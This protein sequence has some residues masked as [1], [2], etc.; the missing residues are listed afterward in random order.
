MLEAACQDPNQEGSWLLTQ[1]DQWW[2]HGNVYP[3]EMVNLA[4]LNISILILHL[5]KVTIASS[6]EVMLKQ[7]DEIL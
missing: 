4:W 5:E 1:W 3:A 7:W 6:P 2:A